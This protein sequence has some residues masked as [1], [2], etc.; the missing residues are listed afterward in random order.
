MVKF[1]SSIKKELND[2]GI[3]IKSW[4]FK[5]ESFFHKKA[6]S[7]NIDENL[8]IEDY[9]KFLN[10]TG[11]ETTK[12]I[13]KMLIKQYDSNNFRE[14]HKLLTMDKKKGHLLYVSREISQ[15]ERSIT[16]VPIPRIKAP[17]NKIIKHSLKEIPVQYSS[18]GVK[19]TSNKKYKRIQYLSDIIIDDKKQALQYVK[20]AKALI[21]DC[22]ANLHFI[23]IEKRLKKVI[24]ILQEIVN[25][26][27][28][29]I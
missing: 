5:E 6:I 21:N 22:E 26:Y 12:E 20:L 13:A 2:I 15:L 28:P 9:Y 7:K 17:A 8:C 27:E 1:T 19:T 23:A 24:S 3:E 16:F 11:A 18:H 14:I 10:E 29:L 4:K 25:E